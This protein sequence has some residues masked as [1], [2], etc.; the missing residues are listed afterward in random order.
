MKKILVIDDEEWLREMM[1]LAL[2][3]RGFEVIEAEN[4][5]K[6]IEIA[7]RELPDLILCDVNMDKVDGY[8]TLSSLR[9]EPATASIPFILMTGLA[10]Q[11][12]MRHG[13]ELG[14]DDYLPK[15]FTIE[16]LYAAVDA[17]LKKAKTVR[18]EAERKLADL[19]DNISMMLP[20][21]LRTPLN[22]IL[23]YGEIL[24][25]DA[26]TIAPKDIADM[27]QV[28][29]DSGKRLERLIENFLIYAQLELLN[30]DPQNLTNLLRKQ[31]PAPAPLIEKHAREQA[32]LAKRPQDL[33]LELAD[34]A[35]PISDEYLSKI[36]DEL[37]QNAFKFSPVGSP[38]RV[39]LSDYDNSVSLTVSD[40]GR[41]FSTEHI[42]KVGAYMQFDRKLHEQQ[43]LGLGLTIVRRLTEMHGGTLSIQSEKGVKTAVTVKLPK[44]MA[45]ESGGGVTSGAGVL[46]GQQRI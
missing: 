31:T 13:M 26:E 2:R 39:T 41:G 15:P 34:V 43:G 19:R 40:V 22:G 14:A 33:K 29:Y 17:R 24:V 1:L 25:A 5:E 16:A 8:L 36:V 20:H 12:G 11:A 30:S 9:S 4:G 28:I 27:G 46:A 3:Q 38:V 42:T 10:D 6:G 32:S 21:E 18:E 44:V 37:V 23:A 7:R 35:M 45:N